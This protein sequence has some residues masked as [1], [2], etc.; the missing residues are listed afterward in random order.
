MAQNQDVRKPTMDA[1]YMFFS[2]LS[3]EQQSAIGD[4]EESDGLVKLRKAWDAAHAPEAA[5][6]NQEAKRTKTAR[7]FVVLLLVDGGFTVDA[8]GK[9][10]RALSVDYVG[11]GMGSAGRESE[12]D[13][14]KWSDKQ[15]LI[16]KAEIRA[17]KLRVSEKCPVH[18]L[19]LPRT[20]Y[21]ESFAGYEET[22]K[23]Q[24]TAKEAVQETA[25]ESAAAE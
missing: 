22:R 5:A 3:P 6:Q 18:I 24:E 9:V 14:S 20:E 25:Q 1:L 12:S 15:F 23:A 11:Q 10:T 21:L 19:V 17:A 4:I 2:G 16:E 13:R 8:K 7:E